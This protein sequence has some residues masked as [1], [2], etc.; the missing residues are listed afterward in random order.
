MPAP[1][2]WVSSSSRQRGILPGALLVGTDAD[3]ADIYAGRAYHEGATLPAKVIPSK[4]ACYI[5]Y[6]GEEVLKDEFEVL[7]SIIFTWKFSKDGLVPP[8]ALEAGSTADGEKLYFGRVLH[9]GGITPGKIQ[10]SHGVC[11]YA[12][13]G[14]E[15]ISHEYQVLVLL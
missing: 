8:D 10:P 9:E 1:Y 4:S 14:E 11:Y 12:F 3:G 5:S 6:D 2:R 13:G 7:V 15:R